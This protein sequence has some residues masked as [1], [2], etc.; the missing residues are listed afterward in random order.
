MTE[1]DVTNE[2]ISFSYHKRNK[3]TQCGIK[4]RSNYRQD[5]KIMKLRRLKR[6]RQTKGNEC[7]AV[8]V[9]I[10]AQP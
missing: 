2:E 6:N 10:M 8:H 9:K 4:A 3:K 7:D 1:Y 5:E